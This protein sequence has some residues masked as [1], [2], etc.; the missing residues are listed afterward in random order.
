MD[1]K[2]IKAVLFDLGETL[3]NYGHIKTTSAIFEAGKRSYEYLKK[4]HQP[5][6]G[7]ASY[8]ISNLLSIRIKS[9]LAEI[10]GRD[11]DSLEE[12]K[13]FGKR[14]K[15]TLT[16]EQWND[17]NWF[18][19]EPL[20][21]HAETEPNLRQT[22]AKMRDSGIKLGIISNTF[23]NCSALDRHLTEEG[24]I[25][26]FPMRLFSYQY[27]CRKPNKHIFIEGARKI[28]VAPENVIYVGDRIDKDVKGSAR[29]G[30]HPVLKRT[31]TNLGKKCPENVTV[32]EKIS[33]LPDLIERINSGKLAI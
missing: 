32:I 24:I 20:T 29:A 22:L 2:K 31:H 27:K 33:E 3:I 25:D 28:G 8:I 23:V 16:N 19:Y 4:M 12:L 21:D 13:K 26:Y 9:M 15:F 18:W 10:I 11:F 30:M 6:G 5:V 1:N 7:F 14:K 17:F